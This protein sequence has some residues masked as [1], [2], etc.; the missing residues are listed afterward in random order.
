MAR[1]TRTSPRPSGVSVNLNG[2]QDPAVRQTL[3]R[4]A[5]SLGVMGGDRGDPLDRAVTLRDLQD[6][7]MATITI[8]SGGGQVVGPSEPGSGE[9]GEE[10]SAL[11][12]LVATSAVYNIILEWTGNVQT[13]FAHAEV[14][15]SAT[16]AVGTAAMIGT[17]TAE[18]YADAVG[19]ASQTYYYW[20]R[21]VND[22]G[23]PGPWNA[24]SGT[25][26]STSLVG[27]N[28]LSQHMITAAHL[29]DAERALL[30]T[31]LE[32]FSD[33]FEDENCLR[34]WEVLY[35]AGGV[36]VLSRSA[37][38]ADTL[39]QHGG[40]FLEA[41]GGDMRIAH[42][43]LIP[44]DP[45][46]TYMIE[47]SARRV[48]GSGTLYFGFSGV[49]GDGVTPVDTMGGTSAFHTQHYHGAAATLP[50]TAAYETHRG[51]SSGH[52]AT[53]G[54]AAAGTRTTPGQFHPAVR[55]LRP[56]VILNYAQ[57]SGANTRLAQIRVTA[58]VTAAN[59]MDLAVG[60]AA[61]Q[62][63]AVT[64][65][66]IANLAV[67]SAK[68]ADASIVTAKIGDAQITNAKIGN[69]IESA[70]GGSAW[71]VNKAG[72]AHFRD[73]TIYDS[74]GDVILHSGEPHR[75]DHTNLAHRGQ[76]EDGSKGSW[77]SGTVV[78]GVV[79]PPFERAL[80]QDT[81]SSF[82]GTDSDPSNF[83]AVTGGETLY[84]SG[85]V[86]TAATT[87][88]CALGVKTLDKNG[89]S[90][91]WPR[92]DVAAGQG[93]QYVSG[94]LLVPTTAT[95]ALPWTFINDTD[96]APGPTG[97]VYWTDLRISRHAIGADSTEG[98][99]NGGVS[100]N[101]SVEIA[102]GGQVF[103]GHSTYAGGKQ[104]MLDYNGGDPRVF[105]G[106]PSGHYF[107]YDGTE[108]R[109]AG[110]IVGQDYVPGTAHTVASVTAYTSN[111]AYTGF[112]RI[113]EITLVRYGSVRASFELRG[114]RT[115]TFVDVQDYTYTTTNAV[116]RLRLYRPSTA[117]YVWSS[118][119]YTA[120]AAQT[121]TV[122]VPDIRP[123]DQL[124]LEVHAAGAVST[125][126]NNA[127]DSPFL[128][129]CGGWRLRVSD[130][131]TETVTYNV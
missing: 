92:L 52:G 105:F 45:D 17:T 48:A 88:Q 98:A 124:K 104:W 39:V 23:T 58:A 106:D 97:S 32:I 130:Y 55:Y 71:R 42:K 18:V 82:E 9:V 53:I 122:D 11:R 3:Q 102:G 109:V 28:D 70:D 74:N 69:I 15:R 4:L 94:E 1:Q 64:N 57:V 79:G 120:G 99:L 29:A 19:F 65:A 66:K 26:A 37:G 61:I 131:L 108:V 90:P 67:D 6:S 121:F 103:A 87:H 34:D 128:T 13:G 83:F 91:G 38:G 68:I 59:I 119:E 10:L 78:S 114:Q 72:A 41:T 129:S 86:Y 7:G 49:A 112:T 110:R 126:Y 36:G 46:K 60:N 62:N 101:G 93:W 117:S 81:R 107:K 56:F 33:D 43:R 31:G 113:K 12:D 123:G 89:V 63:L 35:N 75:I 2:V 125:T 100:T 116:A 111:F 40:A 20:V 127:S 21:P 54:T 27:G 85:W 50:G 76:F 95:K 51:Y 25:S 24:G 73:I 14:W 80:K 115:S 77:T 118:A 96:G 30:H 22:E 16:D 44:Y 8:G 5:E 84:V 47:A